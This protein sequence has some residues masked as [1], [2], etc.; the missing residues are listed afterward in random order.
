MLGKSGGVRLLQALDAGLSF[1]GVNGSCLCGWIPIYGP[2][3]TLVLWEKCLVD[4]FSFFQKLN[5][6]ST[7][8]TVVI[9][10]S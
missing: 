4:V 9:A 3:H 6:I 8:N 5:Y 1:V 2:N 10:D 7:V